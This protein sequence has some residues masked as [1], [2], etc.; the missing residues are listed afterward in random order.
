MKKKMLFLAAL[1]AATTAFISCSSDEDLAKVPEVIEEPAAPEVQGTPFKINAYAEGSTRATRYNA[2]AWTGENEEVW[3]SG[4]KL[5][6]KQAGADAAWMNNI[7]FSR[8]A[9][10]VT[11]WTPSDP[12]IAWPADDDET[13]ADETAIPT[14]FY[15]V[16]DGTSSD[17]TGVSQW[18]STEGA[19]SFKFTTSEVAVPHIDTTLGTA[20]LTED[21]VD[22][23]VTDTTATSMA[24][25]MVATATKKE[26]ETTDGVLPLSFTHALSG[27]AIK[28]IF[29]NDVVSDPASSGSRNA[30]I[31]YIKVY[32]LNTSGTYTFGSGW[33]SLATEGCYYKAFET[34]VTIPAESEDT[35][36]TA[37]N[38]VMLV[39]PGEWLVIP[40]TTT[41]WD[42][43]V[44][45]SGDYIADGA[46]YIVLGITDDYETEDVEVFLPLNTTFTAGKNK[47]LRI[48]LGTFRDLY[49]PD[50]DDASKASYYFA[51]AQGGGGA[52]AFIIEEE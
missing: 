33:S 30:L 23:Y 32:G 4:F 1:A 44:Q 45:E 20:Y 31:H 5:W 47:T 7:V 10:N 50:D 48:D 52:P 11:E 27:L 49:T 6:G 39:H 24:D 29:R 22:T 8:T 36:A 17:A 26:S 13:D 51:P 19:F 2:D 16:T 41:P 15:A 42:G 43:G 18:M 35:E 40:Q 34:P 25:L 46:A 37:A 38:Y 12:T 28:L 14:T 9:Y 3:V 21:G